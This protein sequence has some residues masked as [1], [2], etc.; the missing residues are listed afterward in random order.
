MSQGPLVALIHATPLVIEPARAAFA[1]VWP[2]AT[3]WNLL[4]DRL[5][6]EADQA[7]GITPPLQERMNTLIGQAV[8]GGAEGVLLTC[9]MYGPVLAGYTGSDLPRQGSD[10]AMYAE[11]ARLRPG[12][13]AVLGTTPSTVGDSATRL[14][15]LLPQAEVQAVVVEGGLE[16][17]RAGDV[18]ALRERL[19]ATAK[20]AAADVDLILIA[21]YSL[22]PG[23]DQEWVAALGVPVL[24]P[25][26]LAA[27]RLRDQ[28]AG[29]RS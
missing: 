6:L 10:E 16:A 8:A 20:A 18:E 21:Q 29:E 19:S 25:A 5:M 23:F 11:A 9:S 27:Q 3:L 28:V 26:D 12:R 24:S 17:A 2:E 1:R 7:G 15:G 14:R 22:T 4:D 13:V